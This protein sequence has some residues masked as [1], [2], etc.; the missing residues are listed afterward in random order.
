MDVFRFVP[1]YEE[2]IYGAGKEPLLLLLI[3]FLLAFALTRLYTRL[4]RRHGWG[5]GRLGGIHVH[6]MVPGLVAVLLS[7]LIAFS[8]YTNPAVVDIAAFAFGAGAALVL[9]EFALVFHLEDVYWEDEGR[10]S[11]VATV[12][13]A[14]V[15]VL[16]LV[17]TAPAGLRTDTFSDRSRV[18]AAAY[19]GGN[20]LFAL[21]SLL[22]G[23][24][25]VGL[26]AIFVPVVGLVGAVR[27]AHPR[28]PWAHIFYSE[29]KI[30]RSRDRFSRCLGQRTRNRVVAVLGGFPHRPATGS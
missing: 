8:T 3:S 11:V 24:P 13:G 23:K 17:V 10:Q 4:Q 7:G 12:L 9:D 16:M 21:M 28:S 2:E 30:A 5:S 20:A 26:T 18:Y 27:F 6:H 15:I 22:K 14:A 19:L 29:A 1:G 25:F